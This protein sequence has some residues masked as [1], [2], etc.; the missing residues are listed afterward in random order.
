MALARFYRILQVSPT[1][2]NHEI[3]KALT[4]TRKTA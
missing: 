1:T 4:M 2:I 3:K